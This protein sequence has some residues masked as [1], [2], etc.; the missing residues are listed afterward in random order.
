M[1]N[2]LKKKRK[3]NVDRVGSRNGLT[4]RIPDHSLVAYQ[5]IL[6][7]LQL[8]DAEYFRRY[9]RMDTEV[10]EVKR[11]LQPYYHYYCR[12][13]YYYYYYYYYFHYYYFY[14]YY[15]YYYYYHY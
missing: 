9:L 7:D 6:S 13:Y 4:G 14:Y 5:T 10:Y 2:L 12:H 3:E 1:N 15:Y 11:F 8:N